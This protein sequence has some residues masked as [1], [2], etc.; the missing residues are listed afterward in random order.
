ML[1]RQNTNRKLFTGA[2]VGMLAGVSVMMFDKNVRS[3]I[4]KKSKRI[5]QFVRGI[6]EEPSGFF[7]NIKDG[8]NQISKSLKAISSELKHL[9]SQIEE[10]KST[11]HKIIESA[12]D[13]EKGMKEIGSTLIN[14]NGSSSF[15]NEK[16]RTKLH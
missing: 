10:I 1:G 11:S 16:D 9:S 5:K 12:K 2:I 7:N 14:V 13:A 3:E 6:K 4:A 15:G 8:I